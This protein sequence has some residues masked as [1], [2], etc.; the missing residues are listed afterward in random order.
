M[1]RRTRTMNQSSNAASAVVITLLS[2]SP[3]LSR[4]AQTALQSL[5]K[6]EPVSIASIK[7]GDALDRIMPALFRSTWD[8]VVSREV[9]S[10]TIL[11]FLSIKGSV[12]NRDKEQLSVL[13]L[14]EHDGSS[15][16]SVEESI[17]LS[18][19]LIAEQISHQE[20]RSLFAPSSKM[21]IAMKHS[22][23]GQPLTTNDLLGFGGGLPLLKPLVGASL[24]APASA[25]VLASKKSNNEPTI[26]F[27][28]LCIPYFDDASY[29]DGST[30]LSTLSAS[31]Y[32]PAVG[33][34]QFHRN[35][36]HNGIAVR[37]LP[38]AKEDR[39]LPF[40]S[41]VFYKSNDGDGDKSSN[42]DTTGKDDDGCRT[43]KI[44]FSS[45]RT[46]QYM[47]SHPDLPGLDIRLS[48]KE[49]F[50]SHFAE[51]QQALLAGSLLELQSNNVLLEGGKSGSN[52]SR[53]DSMNGLGD[54]WV[55]FRANMKQPSG[56]INK[57]SANSSS[58]SQLRVAKV[59]DIPYE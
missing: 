2:S 23:L 59:P 13:S 45:S 16:S 17:Q 46:G 57:R 42:S 3:A 25:P 38:S 55:E 39:M 41:L 6:V 44:G 53:S 1:L 7:D 54:C 34:Y 35:E 51:A 50:S 33:L 32:R 28:E 18:R 48:D 11:H 52:E 20:G 30:L 49:T 19:N 4:R 27:K 31:L 9:A 12:E 36:N 47:V 15:S 22:L 29:P 14:V 37:P 21:R 10:G 8:S 56:F 24:E 26:R 5:L 43:A 58:S 40:P